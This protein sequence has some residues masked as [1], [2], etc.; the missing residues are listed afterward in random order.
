[1]EQ[2]MEKVGLSPQL[3]TRVDSKA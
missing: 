2:L 3:K 1:M